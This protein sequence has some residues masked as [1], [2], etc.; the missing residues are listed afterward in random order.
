MQVKRISI[1]FGT[2][3][4][5]IEGN[6]SVA[7]SQQELDQET[8]SFFS[9]DDLK[10]KFKPFQKERN[11]IG[12]LIKR[13]KSNETTSRF[14]F[15]RSQEVV[16]HPTTKKKNENSN[17]INKWSTT[18][19]LGLKKR[20]ITA[21]DQE[22]SLRQ[23][24]KYFRVNLQ[25]NQGFIKQFR[26]YKKQQTPATIQSR[27]FL[28]PKREYFYKDSLIPGPG[29]YSGRFVLTDPGQ[30]IEYSKS[31]QTPKQKIPICQKDF[32]DIQLQK[33][34]ENTPDFLRTI[35]RDKAYQRSIFAQIEIQ[36]K[37]CMKIK[38]E[39]PIDQKKIQQEIEYFLSQQQ[40][41]G[42]INYQRILDN[43]L[44]VK[45]MTRP[46]TLDY[47]WNKMLER[48]GFKKMKGGKIIK[49]RVQ[50]LQNESEQYQFN[51]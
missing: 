9:K 28:A 48:Y 40:K 30:S 49:D 8:Q 13:A 25:A 36:K 37:E 10:R 47:T 2:F 20:D 23:R 15:L 18:N 27:A 3:D 33:K 42:K 6:V 50:T 4:Q 5:L 22:V 7:V 38:K 45:K 29:V 46:D 39:Q 31:P 16:V 1:E 34:N 12:K 14:Q 11:S 19:L 26:E 35:S 44:D 41:Y 24:L 51:T 21:Q 32:Y 17:M 43:N